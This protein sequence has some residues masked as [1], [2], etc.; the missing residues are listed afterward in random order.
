MALFIA[1]AIADLGTK[2]KTSTK[3]RFLHTKIYESQ[4]SLVTINNIV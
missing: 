3:G 4:I 1:G 2:T